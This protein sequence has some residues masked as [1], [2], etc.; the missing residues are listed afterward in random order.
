MTEEHK[1]IGFIIAMRVDVMER[2]GI[3]E[4]SAGKL[5]KETGPVDI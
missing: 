4:R 2:S 5:N 3:E 1:A